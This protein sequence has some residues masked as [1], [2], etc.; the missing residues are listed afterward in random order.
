M[1]NIIFKE[2]RIAHLRIIPLIETHE[3]AQVQ[4]AAGLAGIDS[5]FAADFFVWKAINAIPAIIEMVNYSK[6]SLTNI[7]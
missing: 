7:K 6:K 5:D 2:D 3:D 4:A 1:G